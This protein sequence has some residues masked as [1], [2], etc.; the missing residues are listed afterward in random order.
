MKP[1]ALV[2]LFCLGGQDSRRESWYFFGYMLVFSVQMYRG[3][4]ILKESEKLYLTTQAVVF[5][6]QKHS[7]HPSLSES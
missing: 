3:L 4:Y 5:F 1:S 6:S 2:G 7:R